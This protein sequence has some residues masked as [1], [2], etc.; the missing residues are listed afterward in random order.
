MMSRAQQEYVSAVRALVYET[1]LPRIQ[2]LQ[3]QARRYEDLCVWI[4]DAMEAA[5]VADDDLASETGDE[6]IEQ[7]KDM[8][9]GNRDKPAD[10]A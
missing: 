9:Y 1:E 8:Q 4:N 2:S 10:D 6:A 3:A 7:L 5:G